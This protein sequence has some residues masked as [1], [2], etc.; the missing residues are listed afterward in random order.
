MSA[1]CVRKATGDFGFLS[2]ND[3]D[4]IARGPEWPS[5]SM[6]HLPEEVC[7]FQALT[8]RLHREASSAAD[9]M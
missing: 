2:T 8:V 3:L 4:L 1:E 6:Q 9:W 7:T 5:G